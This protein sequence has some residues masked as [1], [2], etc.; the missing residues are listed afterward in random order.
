MGREEEQPEETF[1]IGRNV[2]T[3]YE[4][5][6]TEKDY[7]NYFQIYH[8]TG[9]FKLVQFEKKYIDINQTERDALVDLM[10]G[11]IVYERDG[12]FTPFHLVTQILWDYFAQCD[13]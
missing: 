10:E 8:D 11:C 4:G 13:A 9:Q 12:E 5:A 1:D 7:F 6:C 3:I 2:Y